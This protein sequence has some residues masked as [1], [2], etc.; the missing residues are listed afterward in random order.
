MLCVCVSI[1]LNQNILDRKKSLALP[2]PA[3]IAG[4][5]EPGEAMP[6]AALEAP[7]TSYKISSI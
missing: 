2:L 6:S 3:G 5:P 1:G 7:E 4:A